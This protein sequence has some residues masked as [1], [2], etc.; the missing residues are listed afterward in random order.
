LKKIYLV[1]R[2]LL[3]M[4]L[5]LVLLRKR[6]LKLSPY[7]LKAKHNLKNYDLENLT[8]VLQKLSNQVIDLKRSTEEASSS[9][10]PYK[11]PFRKPFPTNRPNPNPEGL[12][13]ESL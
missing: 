4:K 1:L 9:K 7:L 8:K 13:L 10:G 5:K 6:R 12:N 2:T 3:A 11:P